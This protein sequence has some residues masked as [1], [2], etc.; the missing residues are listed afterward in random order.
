[1]RL[2]DSVAIITGGGGGMGRG[3]CQ[4]LARAGADL[5]PPQ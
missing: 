1:M 4:R 2:Q 5:E 3:I